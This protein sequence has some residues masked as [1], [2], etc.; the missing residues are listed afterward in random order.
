MILNY[1]YISQVSLS[2][3]FSPFGH[4]LSRLL[5]SYQMFWFLA[6]FWPENKKK[7][8]ALL[9]FSLYPKNLQFGNFFLMV[10]LGYF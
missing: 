8:D 10:F 6:G 4:S 2:P 5:A 3:D 9:E 7:V 1:L